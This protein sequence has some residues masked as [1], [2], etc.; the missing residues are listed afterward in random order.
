[1]PTPCPLQATVNSNLGTDHMHPLEVAIEMERRLDA[2]DKAEAA[3]AEAAK[4]RFT[5]TSGMLKSLFEQLLASETGLS[6]HGEWNQNVEKVMAL[7]GSN[8]H[9]KGK[10]IKTSAVIV[11]INQQ[12]KRVAK[13]TEDPRFNASSEVEYTEL[14]RLIAAFYQV[15][16]ETAAKRDAEKEENVQLKGK[17]AGWE[18]RLGFGLGLGVTAGSGGTGGDGES[19][20]DL[21]A[22]D[23]FGREPEDPPPQKKA[24]Q[25]GN[26]RRNS[27]EEEGLEDLVALVAKAS[28]DRDARRAAEDAAKAEDRRIDR[29]RSQEM[30]D[31]T[32][33]REL[34]HNA[35]M[36]EMMKGQTEL[37]KQLAEK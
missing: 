31:L 30:W 13:L 28:A 12:C 16:T 3:E 23:A 34:E 21:E 33:K 9:F 7:V 37:L 8:H 18:D 25:K 19:L 6:K 17:L 5:W 4:I 24:K 32:V 35:R 22:E 10:K 1:M 26:S 36:V 14:D 20:S 15:R 11:K 29:R 27:N 2:E